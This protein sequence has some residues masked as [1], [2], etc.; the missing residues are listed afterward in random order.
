MTASRVSADVLVRARDI[1][2]SKGAFSR[3]CFYDGRCYCLAGAL[4]VA[5]YGEPHHNA[6][7]SLTAEEVDPVADA[8]RALFPERLDPEGY[9]PITVLYMFN[10]HEDTTLPDLVAVLD[11]ATA[12]VT[13]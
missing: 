10:D 13:L 12:L 6:G 1:I 2:T 8:V 7:A 5:I 11:A 9:G 3:K 4:G